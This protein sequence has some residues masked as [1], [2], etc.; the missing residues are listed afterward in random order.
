MNPPV[1]KGTNF[2]DIIPAYKRCSVQMDR[3]VAGK[4][5]HLEGS[6]CTFVLRHLHLKTPELHAATGNDDLCRTSG[7]GV[8]RGGGPQAGSA[9]G[10]LWVYL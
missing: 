8:H 3:L 9:R 6:K 4:G 2:T 1:S 10:E 5:C 7:T